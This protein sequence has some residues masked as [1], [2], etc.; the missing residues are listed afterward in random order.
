MPT[1]LVAVLK[2]RE[3]SAAQIESETVVLCSLFL[4]LALGCVVAAVVDPAIAGAMEL[5]GCY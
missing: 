3:A 4:V 5:L 2:P 1:D